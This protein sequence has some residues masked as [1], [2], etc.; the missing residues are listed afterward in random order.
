MWYTN[1]PAKQ[2]MV[3][4]IFSHKLCK[5]TRGRLGTKQAGEL[6]NALCGGLV[7]VLDHKHASVVVCVLVVHLP[8]GEA[9]KSARPSPPKEVNIGTL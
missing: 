1:A 4:I 2:V 7:Q 6:L 3:C 9:M 8:P 5:E